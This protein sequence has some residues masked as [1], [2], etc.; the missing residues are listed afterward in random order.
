MTGQLDLEDTELLWPALPPDILGSCWSSLLTLLI[1]ECCDNACRMLNAPAR[2]SCLD[3]RTCVLKIADVAD[4]MTVLVPYTIYA[5]PKP[6][7]CFM[8]ASPCWLTSLAER[9][10]VWVTHGP[11]ATERRLNMPPADVAQGTTRGI[12]C[13]ASARSHPWIAHP[14]GTDAAPPHSQSAHLQPWC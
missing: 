9:V 6:K 8:M 4:H 10:F 14:S 13:P 2:R 3:N 5:D 1:Q 12:L 11:A 7:S